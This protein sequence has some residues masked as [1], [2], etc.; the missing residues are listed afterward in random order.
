MHEF[1]KQVFIA[2]LNFNGSLTSMVN[3]SDH[4]KCISLG[5][6]PCMARP[7]LIDLNL[8]QIIKDCLTIYSLLI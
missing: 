2:F 4:T 5:N 1:F 6:Q 8:D 3:V 7:T